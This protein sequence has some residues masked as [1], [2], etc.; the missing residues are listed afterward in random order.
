MVGSVFGFLVS[1]TQD[2]WLIAL[3]AAI[4]C[5]FGLNINVDQMPSSRN[6]QG[7]EAACSDPAMGYV[8]PESMGS[9]CIQ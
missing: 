5:D 1:R 3:C 2:P 8:V 9:G 7:Q 6:D 4:N